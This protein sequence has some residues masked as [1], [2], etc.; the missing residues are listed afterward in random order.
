MV[1]SVNRAYVRGGGDIKTHI[2]KKK[3]HL[4]QPN[5]TGLIIVPGRTDYK[6]S[7]K[8]AQSQ[9]RSD[10]SNLVRT[11]AK[12]VDSKLGAFQTKNETGSDAMKAELNNT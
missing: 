5:S 12:T 6:H 9:Q 10:V 1:I 7:N 11:C 8:L 3:I 2:V 4:T